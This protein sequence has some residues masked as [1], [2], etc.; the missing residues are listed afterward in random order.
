MM[1]KNLSS[2]ELN[3]VM[4]V[5]CALDLLAVMFY[6]LKLD[7]ANAKAVIN[8]RRDYLAMRD[9]FKKDREENLKLTVNRKIKY[10]YD[11]SIILKCKLLGKTTYSQL[12]E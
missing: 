3:G 12:L 10:R 11:F 6:L 2:D 9:E 1:Y 4:R 5:R 8:A 7:M